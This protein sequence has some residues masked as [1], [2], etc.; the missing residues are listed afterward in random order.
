MKT[1]IMKRLIYFKL[2]LFCLVIGVCEVFAADIYTLDDVFSLAIQKAER[3]KIAEEDIY[4]AE[5]GRDKAFANLIPKLS[6]FGGFTK[7]SE[8][9]YA[10]GTT[11]I[12]ADRS[13]SYGLRLDQTYSIAGKEFKL[14]D[15]S[16]DNIEKTRFDNLSVTNDYLLNVAISFYDTLKAQKYVQIAK[17]NLERLEK[18]KKAAEVRLKV[19][20]VTRT[21]LL[22]AEAELSGARTELIKTENA[23][24]LSK[25]VLARLIGIT[26]DFELK[27]SDNGDLADI[28]NLTSSGLN[29]LQ[30]EALQKRTEVQSALLQQKM[31]ERQI[32][33][34]ETNYYPSISLEGVMT[35]AGMNPESLSLVKESVYGAIKV[36]FP[37]FEGGMRRAEVREAEAKGRQAS[38]L[39]EDT[40]K[41]VLIDVQRAYL[42]YLTSKDSLKSLQDQVDF[43]KDNYNAVSRQFEFGLA[44]SIDV[45]DANNLLVTSEQKF[46]ET[47]YNYRLSILKLKRAIGKDLIKKEMK[48]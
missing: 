41:S 7:F 27:S 45:M 9:K 11:V 8:D 5:M 34:A 21:A 39:I 29:N 17:S 38:L 15:S 26:T 4:I 18:H 1:E 30:N 16:K 46:Y 47:D 14:Y 24:K 43:A 10:L 22:R 42:D 23:F 25:A 19:G 3:L 13:Y 44:N 36:N 35:K 6:V 31:A 12:Q 33:I 2:F 37:L 40:K 48:K 28:V 32:K 20:E